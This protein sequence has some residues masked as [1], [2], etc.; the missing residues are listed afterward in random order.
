MLTATQPINKIAAVPEESPLIARDMPECT[1]I[2]PVPPK[3]PAASAARLIYQQFS[4]SLFNGLQPPHIHHFEFGAYNLS[5]CPPSTI[6][7]TNTDREL[8]L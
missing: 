6:N 7:R 3:S 1:E 5:F 4:S 2:L 8:A